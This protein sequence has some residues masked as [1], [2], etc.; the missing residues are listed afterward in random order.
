MFRICEGV[1]RIQLQSLLLIV[2]F[3]DI[4]KD[5]TWDELVT[6]LGYFGYSQIQ[7]GSSHITFVLD[8]RG[9]K[10]MVAKPHP[11]NEVKKYALK[12]VKE[13]L[14]ENGLL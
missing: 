1:T 3:L 14:E 2:R 9:L 13:H 7:R 6:L 4:P 11:G 10:V 5:F 12:Q 8:E